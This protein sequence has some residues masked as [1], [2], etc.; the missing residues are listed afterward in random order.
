MFDTPG[1][2]ELNDMWYIL[3]M[4]E[5][6]YLHLERQKGLDEQD[7]LSK[8]KRKWEELRF[9]LHSHKSLGTIECYQEKDCCRGLGSWLGAFRMDANIESS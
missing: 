3:A 9:T 6:C 7:I 8:T 4:R 5:K 1:R 2:Y